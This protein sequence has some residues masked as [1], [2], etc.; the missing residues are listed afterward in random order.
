MSLDMTGHIGPVFETDV[1][2]RTSYTSGGYVDGLWVDGSELISSHSVTIQP[3][4]DREIETLEKGGD[5]IT[6]ARRIY[7][8]DGLLASVSQSD[9]WVFQG[10]KWKCYKLDN[11]HWRNYCKAIVARFDE[12]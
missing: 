10:E 2:V 12:Q 4:S 8:N 3:A 1:A 11:R 9:T 7:V 5:R 6:D